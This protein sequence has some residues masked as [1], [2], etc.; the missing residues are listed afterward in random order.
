MGSTSL[1]VP[2]GMPSFL[3]AV[4]P[5]V[6]LLKCK[7]TFLMF[8]CMHVAFM[9]RFPKP[10]RPGR[11]GELQSQVIVSHPTASGCKGGDASQL[12]S[13]LLLDDVCDYCL[14]LCLFF[15]NSFFPHS[16]QLAAGLASRT[17]YEIFCWVLVWATKTSLRKTGWMDPGTPLKPLYRAWGNPLNRSRQS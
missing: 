8:E 14:P 16:W 15:P 10:Q 5:S 13:H 4:L 2:M 12:L 3:P 9:F 6:P 7:I 17:N 1:P 11:D